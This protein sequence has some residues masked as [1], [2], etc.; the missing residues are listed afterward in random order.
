MSNPIQGPFA[1]ED[2]FGD[3]GIDIILDRP[4]PLAGNPVLIA[5]IFSDADERTGKYD[6]ERGNFT[7][8]Q[9]RDTALLFAAA[10]DLLDALKHMT[11]ECPF[12]CSTDRCECGENGNGF[13]NKGNPCEHIQAMRAIAKAT[14]Q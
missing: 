6:N 1:I 13:D 8:H 7:P 5:H 9:A 14:G 12:E 2:I 11:E 10:P 4:L 3:G